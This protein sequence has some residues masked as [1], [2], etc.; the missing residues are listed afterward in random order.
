MENGILPYEKEY[1]IQGIWD[2][3]NS[4]IFNKE[5]YIDKKLLIF[6]RIIYGFFVIYKRKLDFF[7]KMIYAY[8]QAERMK[9]QFFPAEY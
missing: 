1:I 5:N 6:W 8:K 7:V 4:D 9:K 2:Y 3:A